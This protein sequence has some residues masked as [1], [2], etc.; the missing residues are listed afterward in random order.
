MNQFD[1][2]L[3]Q[4]SHT[5]EEVQKRAARVRLMIFDIDG[6]LTD[7]SLHYSEAGQ[8]MKTFNVFDGMGIKLLQKCGIETAIISADP[9]RIVSRRTLDLGIP[10]V[11][12]GIK[13]K[14]VAFESLTE[15]LGIGA[16]AC[17]FI[18]DDIIDLPILTQVGFAASVPNGHSEVHH[19]VHYVARAPGGRG[20]VREVC[21]LILRAQGKFDAVIA[22]YLPVKESCG[23]DTARL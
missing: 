3:N 23:V 14:A 18:G 6:V 11:Y 2:P 20:A 21:D 5:F 8:V 1:T 4:S 22:S 16:D 10:H 19:R 12:T 15:A 7:G 13:N 9:S 17:G